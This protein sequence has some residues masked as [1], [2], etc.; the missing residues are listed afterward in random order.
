MYKAFKSATREGRLIIKP[1]ATI[2][3]ISHELQ[4]ALHHVKVG[5]AFFPSSGKLNLAQKEYAVY[6]RLRS[7]PEWSQFTAAQQDDAWKQVINLDGSPFPDGSVGPQ[8]PP[9]GLE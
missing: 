5:D 7:S 9:P 8:A 3:E 2:Y 1:D 6:Q 4:H